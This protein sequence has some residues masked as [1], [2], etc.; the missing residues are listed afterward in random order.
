MRAY[1]VD[2][3][4]KTKVR[5]PYVVTAI[6][7][8]GGL[9][10]GFDIS[11]MSSFIQQAPYMELVTGTP[12]GK[13]DPITQAG[14]TSS[15]A[16][17]SLLGSLLSGPLSDTIGRRP[18]IQLCTLF[19]MIGA[20][21]QSS[22][23]NMVQL[24][25]GR[26]IAGFGV[27]LASSQAPVYISELSPKKIRG[28]LVG[29]FQWSV[30][31][32]ILIMFAIGIGCSK[33]GYHD[34]DGHLVTTKGTYQTAWAIQIIPGLLMLIG[35]LFLDESPRWLASKGRW[36][37]AIEI[38]SW[39][40][41]KGNKEDAAVKVE[42]EEI[43]EAVVV[44]T[45]TSF[46][47]FDLFKGRT[48]LR[49]TLVG[50]TCQAA[51]QWTGMNVMMYY[52]V[53]IMQMAGKENADLISGLIQYVINVV[54]TVPAFFIVDKVGRRPI[55]IFGAIIMA[56]WLFA[57]AGTLASYSYFVP[58]GVGGNMQVRIKIPKSQGGAQI[59][60]MAVSYLFVATYAPTWGP[61][62]WIYCS[63][64]FP[65]E[66]RA[67]ANGLTTATNWLMNAIIAM[68]T[69]IA[70]TNITWQTYFI[71]ASCCVATAIMVFFFYPETKG[72][73]LEE[74]EQMW[75]SGVPAW[76]SASWKPALPDIDEI[77][78]F[79]GGRVP[80]IDDKP[81]VGHVEDSGKRSEQHVE[82]AYEKSSASESV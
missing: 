74:V 63:E 21:I 58:G 56:A 9:L 36:E 3:G 25:L 52:I 72:K 78:R 44:E 26:I 62:G 1:H 32:G 55:M 53:N 2:V 64:I 39:V 50:V 54:M 7:T 14:I 20:A 30:T 65:M 13:V 10:F 71:F 31:W 75:E 46:K 77:E 47:F 15:M 70:F 17:G 16:W 79:G 76:K 34:D 49:R 69:P 11:S 48:N 45:N 61:V 5:N 27:G 38:I 23:I 42:V 68:I 81:E 51:Q 18:V 59:A 12:D 29:A 4:F 40:Q 41:A 24:I 22:S 33:I 43:K 67:T 82:D 57:E 73:T 19:W 80:S 6:A 35:T 8:M 37:E 28:R 60:A 66:Q